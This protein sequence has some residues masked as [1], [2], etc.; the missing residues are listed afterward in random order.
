M[1]RKSSR[2]RRTFTP[3]FK[4]DAVRLVDEGKS[5]TEVARDLGIA[6]S[7]LQRWKDQLSG[8]AMD[9][10]TVPRRRGPSDRVR[11]LEK[12]LR[13]VIEERDILKKA[14]AYFADDQK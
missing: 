13:D 14:L 2:I 9:A 1:G 5:V 12:R 7:L 10:T 6:R 8:A 4:R 11:E 3:G